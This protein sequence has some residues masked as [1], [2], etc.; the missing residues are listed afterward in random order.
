M[1]WRDDTQETLDILLAAGYHVSYFDLPQPPH[2]GSKSFEWLGNELSYQRYVLRVMFNH[3]Y[4]KVGI[5]QEGLLP[6]GEAMSRIV[7]QAGYV[8]RLDDAYHYLGIV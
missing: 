5:F 8:K 6:Y 4:A 1:A 7:K 3:Y 2:F